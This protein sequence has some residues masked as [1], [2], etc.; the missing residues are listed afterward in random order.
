MAKSE[1]A[2]V[3][4][5][6]IT[7]VSPPLLPPRHTTPHLPCQEDASFISVFAT[8][9]LTE[10]AGG[11]P[12][13]GSCWPPPPPPWTETLCLMEEMTLTFHPPSALGDRKSNKCD[14]QLCVTDLGETKTR[15]EENKETI[16]D[17]SEANT[18]AHGQLQTCPL[19]YH[20][21]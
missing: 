8:R 6:K 19:L 20:K 9:R 17:L 18:S 7:K 10:G 14:G 2:T 1:V 13:C 3:E 4:V 5:P 21:Q 11:D 12:R 16:D 15:T